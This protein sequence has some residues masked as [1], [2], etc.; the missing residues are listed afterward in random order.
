MEKPLKILV[1]LGLIFLYFQ[2]LILPAMT[3]FNADRQILANMKMAARQEGSSQEK[4]EEAAQRLIA[5]GIEAIGH[6]LPP[7]EKNRDR[8]WSKVEQIQARFPGTW[9]FRPASSFTTDGRI[10]RWPFQLEFEGR[11]ATALSALAFLECSGQIT[12][13]RTLSLTAKNSGEVA[14]IL[15]MERLFLDSS[16]TRTNPANGGSR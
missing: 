13:L 14:L 12:R 3:A 16:M 10:V 4:L 11:F 2:K 7:M 15:G 5:D 6:L 9:D 8:L 1:T